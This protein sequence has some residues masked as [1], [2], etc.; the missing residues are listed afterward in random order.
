MGKFM[1]RLML[2]VA[3]LILS[4]SCCNRKPEEAVS[5]L[6][7]VTLDNLQKAYAAEMRRYRW[8]ARFSQQAEHDR[9][10]N[11]ATLFKAISR[12]E[13]IHTENHANLIRAM[14]AEPKEQPIDSLP[15]SET[16]Q[17]LKFALNTESFEY[18]SLYPAM[19]RTAEREKLPEA[20]RQF[21]QTRAAD[22]R[23]R[24][25]FREAI[26]YAGK[27]PRTTYLV[28]PGCG[29]IVTSV[30]TDQ[31]PICSTKNDKFEKI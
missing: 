15:A 14:G 19:T 9:F 10:F 30:K 11:V 1:P 7:Y 3:G 8:Y 31:C 5:T 25:L 13:K 22:A 23:H 29:Y 2:L 28:C 20:V 6:K 26:D 27:I 4:C 17:R 16:L 24:L 21:T 18:E 12:S